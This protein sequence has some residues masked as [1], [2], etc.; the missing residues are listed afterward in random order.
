MLNCLKCARKMLSTKKHAP[1][2]K[3][4]KADLLPILMDFLTE[5]FDNK[6]DEYS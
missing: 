4:I 6:Y 3:F 2:D 1:I 5:K